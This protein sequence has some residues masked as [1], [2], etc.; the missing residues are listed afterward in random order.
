MA[1]VEAMVREAIAAVKAGRRDEGR[2]ILS[3]ATELEERNEE[4]W[5]WLSAC[6]DSLDEQ[7]ICL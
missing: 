5:L 4:A 1:N 7:R 6:V 3:R 2:R